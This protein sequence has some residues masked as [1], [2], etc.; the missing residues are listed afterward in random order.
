VAAALACAHESSCGRTWH[1]ARAAALGPDLAATPLA[2]RPYNLRHAAL[3]LWL[4]S[5]APPAEIAARAGH[6]IHML[7]SVYAHCVP[8]TTR[9]LTR[10]SNTPSPSPGPAPAPRSTAGQTARHAAHSWPTKSCNHR[11]DLSARRP[12]TATHGGTQRDPAGPG[13]HR[14]QDR[15]LREHPS[16]GSGPRS[17]IPARAGSR[18]HATQAADLPGSGPQLARRLRE[19]SPEPPLDRHQARSADRA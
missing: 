7:L 18:R 1:A 2:R 6:S 14:L 10:P 15:D 12:R 16:G 3:S 13:S 4:A 8:R 11:P 9:S 19:R 5:G 17:A